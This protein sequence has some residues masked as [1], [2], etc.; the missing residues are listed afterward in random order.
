MTG[1]IT[2]RNPIRLFLKESS[3]K[4]SLISRTR[5]PL[6]LQDGITAHMRMLSQDIYKNIRN[7]YPIA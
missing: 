1:R 7:N 4:Q 6:Y 3:K 2:W 5:K